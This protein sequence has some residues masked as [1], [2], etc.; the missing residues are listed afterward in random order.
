MTRNH[1]FGMCGYRLFRSGL[2]GLC[3]MIVCLTAW[4]ALPSPGAAQERPTT[5]QLKT[6]SRGAA[7]RVVQ[8]DLLSILEPSGKI[9]SG[10]WTSLRDVDLV[11]RSFGTEYEGV[12]R[13]DAVI[14]HYTDT[15]T[16]KKPADRPVLPYSI[17]AHPIFHIVQLPKIEKDQDRPPRPRVEQPACVNV[18][19]PF[20]PPESIDTDDEPATWFTAPDSFH[21]VQ[22]GFLADIAIR[23][24]KAGALKPDPCPNLFRKDHSCEE[25][26]LAAGALTDIDSAESCPADAGVICYKIAFNTGIELT[27]VARGNGENP[28]PSSILSVTVENFITVS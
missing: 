16:S 7:N 6:L 13:R 19:S 2:P 10:I 25:E 1:R 18:A 15:G 28:V 23:A 9:D 20:G 5:R 4:L 22:A 8:R 24:V 11:T 27:I 3:C 12:C 21:A 26:I 17:E 14:L